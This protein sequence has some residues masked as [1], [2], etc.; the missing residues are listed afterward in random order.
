MSLTRSSAQVWFIGKESDTL[1]S[2][3]LPSNGDALR[4]TLFYHN[5]EAQ[6]QTLI[7]ASHTAVS[8]CIEM[9]KRAHIPYQRIDS[10][11]HILMKLYDEY[12]KLKRTE[13]DKMTVINGIR[14]NLRVI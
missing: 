8:R 13:T 14:K 12:A 3:H 10:C 2:S 4:L 5:D 7:D 9:W 11:I 1:P 6:K